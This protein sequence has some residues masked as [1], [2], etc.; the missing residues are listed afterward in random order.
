[1]PIYISLIRGINV[2]GNKLI[3]MAELRQMYESLGFT[4]VRTH[5]QSG[6]VVFQFPGSDT[7]EIEEQI[8]RGILEH[9]RIRPSVIVRTA[10]E[11]EAVVAMQPYSLELAPNPAS[12]LVMFFNRAPDEG[13][14]DTLR[15]S[16][17]GPELMQFSGKTA[18]FYYSEGIGNSKLTVALIEKRL[19]VICTGRNLNTVTT[20]L[21][22]A[23]EAIA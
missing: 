8:E 5:L 18:Y 12:V 1:M 7:G 21:A 11:L 3:K 4:Q 17:G 14:I 19:G 16:Y 23:N 15:A 13:S 2:G 9:F 6:N 22:L 20:L 10:Q